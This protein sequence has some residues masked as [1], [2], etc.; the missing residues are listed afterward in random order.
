MRAENQFAVF[1]VIRSV[2]QAMWVVA[3][4]I[5]VV[6]WVEGDI[7]VAGFVGSL[8]GRLGRTPSVAG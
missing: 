4:E 2:A 3:P 7:D 1:E 8:V 6:M 5:V